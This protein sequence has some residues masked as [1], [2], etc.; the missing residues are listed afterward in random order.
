MLLFLAFLEITD[1]PGQYFMSYNVS[2][3]FL[4]SF[5]YTMIGDFYFQLGMGPNFGPKSSPKKPLYTQCPKWQANA[6][7]MPV[8]TRE[9]LK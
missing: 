5:F 9:Y 3:S 1:N 6:W 7:I 2:I 8:I 4:Y